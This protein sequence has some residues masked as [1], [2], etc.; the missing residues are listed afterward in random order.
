MARITEAQWEPFDEASMTAIED[1]EAEGRT[2]RVEAIRRDMERVRRELDRQQET[3]GL[4]DDPDPEGAVDWDDDDDQ[5]LDSDPYD[6]D[7]DEYE[8]GGSRFD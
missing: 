6:G 2:T 4:L 8:P 7:R 1:A 3:A 5:A